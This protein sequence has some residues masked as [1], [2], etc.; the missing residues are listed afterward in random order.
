[1]VDLIPEETKEYRTREYWNWRYQQTG[2]GEKYDWLLNT[3]KVLPIIDKALAGYGKDTKVLNLGCG[4]SSLPF[5]LYDRFP[6][7]HSIDFSE[8]VIDNMQKMSEREHPLLK[9]T[10][11]DMREL[12]SHFE[13]ESFDVVIDKGSLDAV[14]SDGC[15]QWTP[16]DEVVED[17]RAVIDGILGV[18][19]PGGLFLSISF[20]QPHFRVKWISRPEQADLSHEQ[21][22]PIYFAYY[23]W[24]LKKE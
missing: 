8:I 1:M 17:V 4:N 7:M 15:S 23:M 11:A 6:N 12:L 18:L 13:G 9:W 3:S 20:G 5:D 14:W 22:G 24:K 19:K 21:V 10:V 2:E 16:S